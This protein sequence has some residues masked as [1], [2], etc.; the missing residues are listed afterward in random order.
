MP[1]PA[2][3]EEVAQRLLGEL[4]AEGRACAVGPPAIMG[5]M[6]AR[7]PTPI[8]PMFLAIVMG[9]APPFRGDCGAI[10]PLRSEP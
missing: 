1:R 10:R 4:E 9:I 7:T 8:V 6:L 5:I 2:A 3:G